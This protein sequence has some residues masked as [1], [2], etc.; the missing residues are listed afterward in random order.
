MVDAAKA[1]RGFVNG[2]SLQD[3][4]NDLQLQMA[5][6][7]CVQIIGEA[8]SRLTAET[9]RQIPRLPWRDIHT[10]RNQIVH[11]YFE[12]NTDILW[13]T[14]RNDLPPL[15]EAIEDYLAAHDEG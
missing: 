15:I 8:A 11:V 5:L 4:N 9:Q 6:A 3:V 1:A 14:V 13:D 10:M 7:H 12:L 2:R